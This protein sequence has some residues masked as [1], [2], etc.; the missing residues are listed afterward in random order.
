MA[1]QL[2]E[3]GQDV[4]VVAMLQAI[5]T[6]YPK[7]KASVAWAKPIFRLADRLDME[8]SILRETGTGSLSKHFG[9]R[10]RNVSNRIKNKLENALH[11]GLSRFNVKLQKSRASSLN[12]LSAMH[13]QALAHYRPGP[14]AGNVILLRNSKQPRGIEPDE[15][16]G[17]G[18]LLQG[19]VTIYEIPGF[20]LGVLD[21][22]RVQ[23]VAGCLKKHLGGANPAGE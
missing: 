10:A 13:S 8:I 3:H 12:S 6:D 11:A 2:A 20:R 23:I 4:P 18:D 1:R 16:L 22:P 5:H 7:V 15:R 14:Y 21:E 17:W 19:D 9:A